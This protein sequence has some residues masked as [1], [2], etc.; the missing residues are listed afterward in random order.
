MTMTR[1][2]ERGIDGDWLKMAAYRTI[3]SGKFRRQISVGRQTGWRE[4]NVV[5]SGARE[6]CEG[7]LC[8]AR[9]VSAK[10]NALR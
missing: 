5:L 7:K 10:C 2:R 8:L 4:T 1:W 9:F 6:F 3:G